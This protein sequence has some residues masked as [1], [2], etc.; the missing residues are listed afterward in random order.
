MRAQVFSILTGLAV[1]LGAPGCAAGPSAKA[2]EA[3]PEVDQKDAA[4]QARDLVQEIYAS[5][6]RGD[7]DGL[8]SIVAPDLFALGPRAGDVFLERGDAVVALTAALRSGDRHKLTSKGL[9]VILAPG[10]HSAW[11]TD[12]IDVN[13]VPC[14]MTAILT[15]A[16]G[17]WVVAA[18]HVARLVTDGQAAKLARSGEPPAGKGGA[19]GEAGEVVKLFRAAVAAPE[20]F[21][22]QLAEGKDVIMIGSG[23][24]QVTRGPKPIKKLWKKRLAAAP[25]LAIQGE[26][27]ARSTADGALAWV[28]AHVDV[29]V[30]DGEPMRYR[31]FAVY[32][33]DGED[34]WRLVLL[35]D[36]VVAGK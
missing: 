27:R 4:R 17:L 21:V 6:R 31:L 13:G 36:A 24:R 11:A 22:E 32:Q 12:T 28:T 15:E 3:A 16:D 2:S 20:Q 26:P 8:Q 18:V 25:K 9:V 33:R 35:Q 23:P 29:S 19:Q 30:G 10:G 7:V 1:A 14:A 34:G 5:L